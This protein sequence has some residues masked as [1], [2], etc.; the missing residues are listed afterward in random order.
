[1]SM[2]QMIN[3]CINT[4][5]YLLS[6]QLL[7]IWQPSSF[8]PNCIIL[9]ICISIIKFITN[10]AQIVEKLDFLKIDTLS[11][12]FYK[13]K[14]P[15]IFYIS[16]YQNLEFTASRDENKTQ[17]A[18]NSGVIFKSSYKVNFHNNLMTDVEFI[19][20]SELLNVFIRFVT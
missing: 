10:R 18:I 5:I 19:F 16:K 15:N 13:I 2:D 11:P 1:M 9:S 4:M 3:L 6:N 17:L 12:F 8:I 14:M 20:S 7:T